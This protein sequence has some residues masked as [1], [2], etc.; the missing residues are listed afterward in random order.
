[1]RVPSPFP[2]F[3]QLGIPLA[4]REPVLYNSGLFQDNALRKHMSIV[5]GSVPIGRDG[6]QL[7]RF[8]MGVPATG[9]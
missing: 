3:V 8:P 9:V 7:T 5:L 1:M 4:G 6:S 2:P